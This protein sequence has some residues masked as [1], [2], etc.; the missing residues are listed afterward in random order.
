MTRYNL[1]KQ[2]K[3][4]LHYE[5]NNWNKNKWR[6]QMISETV[7][8]SKQNLFSN[9]FL[10]I[11]TTIHSTNWDWDPS[12]KSPNFQIDPN[13]NEWPRCT[14]KGHANGFHHLNKAEQSEEEA[15]KR[16]E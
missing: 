13:N 16:N 15:K 4:R 2:T 5:W 8:D 1:T 10:K 12:N 6:K 3:L 9:D 11:F 7:Y 14:K